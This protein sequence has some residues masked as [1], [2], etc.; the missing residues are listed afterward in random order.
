ML[1]RFLRESRIPIMLMPG[2]AEIPQSIHRALY[3]DGDEAQPASSMQNLP[4]HVIR[5]SMI[6][7]SGI[8]S[9]G[10]MI[11]NFKINL[12]V[13]AKGQEEKITQSLGD[14]GLPIL[15]L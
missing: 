7:T 2:D 9:I 8:Q 3:L 15:T 13:L 11:N 10:S 12:I 1:L 6:K 14:L 4:F 5:Q